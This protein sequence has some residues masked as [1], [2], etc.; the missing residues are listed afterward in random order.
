M[1]LFETRNKR[2]RPV[3][4]IS[5]SSH[6]V[7]P[8]HSDFRLLR[9]SQNCSFSRIPP[10]PSISPRSNQSVRHPILFRPTL[11]SRAPTRP[12]PARFDPP[13][14]AVLAGWLPPRPAPAEAHRQPPDPMID[15]VSAVISR[16]RVQYH[17][18]TL[19]TRC[20]L[21]KPRFSRIGTYSS[22]SSHRILATRAAAAAAAA[23]QVDI[24]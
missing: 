7:T 24:V 21:S 22:F 15:L 20:L 2:C 8:I 6:L 17:V 1:I 9:P 11:T 10:V 18:F 23:A 19:Q 16:A 5:P 14:L 4:N 12:V 13:R 3:T